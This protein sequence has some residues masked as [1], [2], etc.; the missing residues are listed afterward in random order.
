MKQLGE[1]NEN[2]LVYEENEPTITIKENYDKYIIGANKENREVSIIIKIEKKDNL[3]EIINI[4]NKNNIKATFFINKKTIS[5]IENELKKIIENNHYIGNGENKKIKQTN[6]LL[7]HYTNYKIKYC[8]TEEE[9]NE[10]LKKC[11]KENMHTLKIEQNNNS[12]YNYIKNNLSK[13]KIYLVRDKQ[14]EIKELDLSIKYIKQ[15]GY[16]II[17]INELLNA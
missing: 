5:E 3:N 14:S 13:G 17:D 16:K 10:L 7:E 2:L 12:L 1:Y 8:L 15:K 11:E 9:D 6:K 4:L